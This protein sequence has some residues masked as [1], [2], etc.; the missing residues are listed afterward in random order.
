MTRSWMERGVPCGEG[1][2]WDWRSWSSGKR[3]CRPP[4]LRS[5]EGAPRKLEERKNFVEF[6]G[7]VGVVVFEELFAGAEG[8]HDVG[9][10]DFPVERVFFGRQC[11]NQLIAIVAC[12]AD[13][14]FGV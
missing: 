1:F 2:G 14:I 10:I 4:E 9:Q 8:A 5:R 6:A 12:A 3:S 13:E 7:E 11:G